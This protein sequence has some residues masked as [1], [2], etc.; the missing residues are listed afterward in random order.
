MTLRDVQE[1]FVVESGWEGYDVYKQSS[2]RARIYVPRRNEKETIVL[3][4]QHGDVCF[5]DRVEDILQRH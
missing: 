3:A 5:H 2:I 4:L 1:R